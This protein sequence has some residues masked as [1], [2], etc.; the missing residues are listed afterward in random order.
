MSDLFF[1]IKAKLLT[2][3]AEQAY[4]GKISDNKALEIVKTFFNVQERI[5]KRKSGEHPGPSIKSRRK[6]SAD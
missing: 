3:A 5:A 2:Q 4:G 1:C 6:N